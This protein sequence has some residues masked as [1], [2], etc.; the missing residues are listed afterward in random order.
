MITS[1]PWILQYNSA[2]SLEW[3]SR[4]PGWETLVEVGALQYSSCR[5]AI[6]EAQDG[7]WSY[8]CLL[9]NKTGR[10]TFPA[11]SKGGEGGGGGGDGDGD[12]DS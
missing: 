1:P 4:L 8:L 2:G 3:S 12:G 11:M 5:R 6:L 7:S 9:G 10:D